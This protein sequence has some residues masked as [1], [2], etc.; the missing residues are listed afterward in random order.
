MQTTASN[1]AHFDLIAITWSQ[2]QLQLCIEAVVCAC[3]GKSSQLSLLKMQRQWK[4]WIELVLTLTCCL[5]LKVQDI[6]SGLELV[7]VSYK[8]YHRMS[9]GQLT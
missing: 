8:D 1:N 5:S 7:C 4:S 2:F 9:P 6:I 3:G